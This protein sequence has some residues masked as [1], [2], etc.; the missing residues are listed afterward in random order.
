MKSKGYIS[1]L[2]ETFSTSPLFPL[3]SSTGYQD[4]GSGYV[5]DPYGY[6]DGGSGF[7]TEL[8]IE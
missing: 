5:A 4:G 6:L 3:A 8:I 2:C 7:L 1:P